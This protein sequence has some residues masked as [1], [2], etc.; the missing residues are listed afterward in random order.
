MDFIR[1]R[2]WCAM[3]KN[4][5]EASILTGKPQSLNSIWTDHINFWDHDEA[6]K[7]IWTPKHFE[8]VI[9]MI[10]EVGNPER[11]TV[12]KWCKIYNPKCKSK[13]CSNEDK[14]KENK[15]CSSKKRKLNLSDSDDDDATSMITHA[16][17]SDEYS[18][19]SDEEEEEEDDDDDEED[20]LEKSEDEE[21]EKTE[22]NNCKPAIVE[23]KPN[24][25]MWYKKVSQTC[26]FI[27]MKRITKGGKEMYFNFQ[28][29]TNG[30]H[31]IK[32]LCRFWLMTGN[33]SSDL[34]T[35]IKSVSK[36]IKCVDKGMSIADM[37]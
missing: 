5:H 19:I 34:K 7:Y 16:P 17:S 4:I 14:K 28:L 23:T 2:G 30:L 24:I 1:T 11:W 22:S 13:K 15:V 9:D 25:S 20:T 37:K 10:D 32:Q 26:Q 12:G 21:E 31:A 29:D 18:D 8:N 33:S 35:V 36:L 27:H 3:I 6:D